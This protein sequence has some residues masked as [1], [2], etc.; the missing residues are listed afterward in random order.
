MTKRDGTDSFRMTKIP[1]S[2]PVIDA[3]VIAEVND[4]LT[5]TGW[6]TTG[7]KVRQLEE[8]VKKLTGVEAAL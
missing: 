5:N 7:P 2:L 8:E 3:D 6:L 1:F 4:C